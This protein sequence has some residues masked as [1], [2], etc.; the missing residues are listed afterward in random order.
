M[1]FALMLAVPLAL[2]AGCGGNGANNSSAPA[3]PSGPVTPVAPPAGKQWR[4]VVVQT[5]DGGHRMGNPGA[6]I[7]LLE[8][9]SRGCPV[10]GAF[11]NSGMEALITKYVNS[12][13]VSYEFRDFWVHGA[14]DVAASLL[15]HCVSTEAFFPILEQM[16]AEQ[17]TLNGRIQALSPAQQQALQAL[18]PAQASLG[19]AEAAGYLDFFKKRGIPEAKARQCLTDQNLLNRLAEINKNAV[20]NKGVSGTPTFFIN[21]QKV[22]NVV[23]WPQLEAALRGAGA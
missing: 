2:L 7:Q 5:P 19:W 6:P 1:R 21:G 3:A 8:Y 4:D 16:Y 9:G 20:D 15:G 13:K 23:T 18:P 12:G 22:E 10:C 17:P 11:A 14:P